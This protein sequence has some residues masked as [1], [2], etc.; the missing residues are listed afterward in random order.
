MSRYFALPV[1]ATMLALVGLRA[2]TTS[3]PRVEEPPRFVFSLGGQEPEAPVPAPP[4]VATPPETA[5]APPPR[6]EPTVIVLEPL[7][8]PA[9]IVRTEVIERTVYVPQ[10]PTVI[11]A[12]TT[13]YAPVIE[14]PPAPQEVV[15]V[16]VIVVVNSPHGRPIPPSRPPQAQQD[17]FFKTIPFQPATPRS[18]RW[19]P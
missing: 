14:A 6:I 15:E 3:A 2:L 13:I 12:P 9:S 16:P 10:Q 17:P 5:P 11:Y 1:L 19:N 7:P 18:P 8:Q 4:S